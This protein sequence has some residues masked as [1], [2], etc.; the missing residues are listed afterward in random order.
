MA[1]TEH[2]EPS[3]KTT[4]KYQS[5]SLDSSMA[6][7]LFQELET[8]ME[9]KKL[10]LQDQLSL[11][12][13]ADELSV[14]THQL[15]QTINQMADRNFFDFVNRY[16]IEAAQKILR[17]E[18]KGH[19]SVHFIGETVGFKSKSAFYAAF[20]KHTGCTPAEFRKSTMVD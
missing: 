18:T 13:L 2:S 11:R 5:S 15:S 6:K 1:S 7:H 9:S 12:Q 10:Y 3:E 4:E 17:D 8:A 20:K 16:R 19:Q 14:T